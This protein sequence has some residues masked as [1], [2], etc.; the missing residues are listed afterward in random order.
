MTVLQVCPLMPTKINDIDCYGNMQRVARY[1][2]NYF[3]K[4]RILERVRI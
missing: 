4:A 2:K 3:R 1:D